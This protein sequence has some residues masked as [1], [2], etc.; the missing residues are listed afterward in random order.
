MLEK[1]VLRNRG[2]APQ[3]LDLTLNRVAE[4]EGDWSKLQ[5]LERGLDSSDLEEA[6]DLGCR[7]R[8]ARSRPRGIWIRG[9]SSW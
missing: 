6:P 3:R 2:Q 7:W 8:R 4:A 1:G 5:D 9:G